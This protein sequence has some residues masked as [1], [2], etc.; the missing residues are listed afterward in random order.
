MGHAAVTTTE[1]R[2]TPR[3]PAKQRSFPTCPPFLSLYVLVVQPQ[4]LE[5]EPRPMPRVRPRVPR[6]SDDTRE[7]G[8][9]PHVRNSAMKVPVRVGLTPSCA[10]AFMSEPLRTMLRK[11]VPHAASR[12]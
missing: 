9:R 2:P 7:L 1:R 4:R 6:G 3:L 8:R 12:S 10:P 11:E 5:P